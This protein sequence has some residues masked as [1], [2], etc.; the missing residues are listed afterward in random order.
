[1]EPKR[2]ENIPGY[3]HPGDNIV[4]K[5]SGGYYKT[6]TEGKKPKKNEKFGRTSTGDVYGNVRTS[7]TDEDQTCPVCKKTAISTCNCGFSDKRC[8]NGHIWYTDRTG[9]VKK[10]NPH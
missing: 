7:V 8:E 2:P 5:S 4:S 1:M 3:E 10:G 9:K 6:F